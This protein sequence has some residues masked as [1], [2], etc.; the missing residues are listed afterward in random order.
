MSEFSEGQ[1]S[2]RR[3]VITLAAIFVASTFVVATSCVTVERPPTTPTPKPS[4]LNLRVECPADGQPVLLERYV[5]SD[6]ALAWQ[7]DA[8]LR[9]A[10]GEPAVPVCQ[11]IVS[12]GTAPYS[13]VYSF[14]GGYEGVVNGAPS[15]LF[16]KLP[17]F[18]PGQLA[19]SYILY[20]NARGVRTG[21]ESFSWQWF[22][23][24]RA[25]VSFGEVNP[26][27]TTGQRVLLPL[28]YVLPA[29]EN[30]GVGREAGQAESQTLEIDFGDGR[31]ESFPIQA[32]R[33][34]TEFE[35]A[36]ARPGSYTVA[37][38]VSDPVYGLSGDA[39]LSLE[40]TV[41]ALAAG[42]A[43]PR[44]TATA[45]GPGTSP[46]GTA[47][48]VPTSTRTA[49]QATATALVTQTAVSPTPTRT[50]AQATAT[51]LAIRTAV[52]TRTHT[53]SPTATAV[54]GATASPTPAGQG[55]QQVTWVLV[56]TNVNPAS[57]PTTW[58]SS[59]NIDPS[60][61]MAQIR[62]GSVTVSSSGFRSQILSYLRG[63]ANIFARHTIDYVVIIN[64][65]PTTLESSGPGTFTALVSTT[66][67]PPN[68]P[69]DALEID[70][71][72]RIIADSPSGQASFRVTRTQTEGVLSYNF[73]AP[74]SAALGAQ[75]T[76]RVQLD[77]C[78]ACNVT[79]VYQ[80][81]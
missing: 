65:P 3:R 59:E 1:A 27:V 57:A 34:Y 8:R 68:F 47:N 22:A 61:V 69:S 60:G 25:V 73:R 31:K 44:V 56:G 24:K 76:L 43:T 49:L 14:P 6:P 33:S 41:A 39:S 77:G 12:G 64:P 58:N 72:L 2:W 30:P 52:A 74:S 29:V 45:T 66:V 38:K 10:I 9:T 50:T 13:V 80:A 67:D 36:Y 16:F 23:P 75:L 46:A 53:P 28:S 11:F 40:V 20:D 78:T 4:A 55:S 35:I 19:M 21:S 81:Q 26:E 17:A 51:A 63:P 7:S 5:L 15:E 48:A 54:G 42:S 32:G 62:E 37:A 71:T 70:E 79:W 18:P